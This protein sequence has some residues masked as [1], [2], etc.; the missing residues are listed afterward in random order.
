MGPR[1]WEVGNNSGAVSLIGERFSLRERDGPSF[2]GDV[3]HKRPASENGKRLGRESPSHPH[4]HV[5]VPTVARRVASTSKC[6]K[7]IVPVS[8]RRDPSTGEQASNGSGAPERSWR[9]PRMGWGGGPLTTE[10]R[11]QGWEWNRGEITLAFFRMNQPASL[12][13]KVRSC[14]C[15]WTL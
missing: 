7:V 5:S 10:R 2:D 12:V 8:R 9:M 4:L 1:A 13:E 14:W 6:G 11:T 15:C 3:H